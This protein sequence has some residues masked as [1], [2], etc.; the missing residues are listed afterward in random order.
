M[1][2][3]I[4]KQQEL[5][6]STDMPAGL[7]DSQ[8]SG[9][10]WTAARLFAQ[11]P[12]TCQQIIGLLA[13]GIGILRVSRI[14]RVSPSTVIAVRD[15]S[16][17]EIENQARAVGRAA[18][19]IAHQSLDA[20]QE[21]ID[22]PERRRKVAPRDW[23][24]IAGVTVDKAQLLAGMPTSINLNVAAELPSHDDYERMVSRMGLGGEAGAQKDGAAGGADGSPA[25]GRPEAGAQVVDVEER[26]GVLQAVT[27]GENHE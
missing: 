18:M 1:V 13:E 27:K 20:I 3:A 23:A 24:I 22:D 21:A 17:T 9:G 10:S 12:E 2:D 7:F 15:Q 26:D 19:S 11:R 6:P 14:C 4:A 5:I 8:E 16:G 25:A